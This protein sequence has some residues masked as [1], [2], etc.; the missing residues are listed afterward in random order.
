MSSPS[1]CS[2][3]IMTGGKLICFSP[4]RAG[5]ILVLSPDSCSCRRG[6][7]FSPAKKKSREFENNILSPGKGVCFYP[8]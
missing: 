6:V 7:A 4:K 3:T 5:A 2:N 1:K 8:E